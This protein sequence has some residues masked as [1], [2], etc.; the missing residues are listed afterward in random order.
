[1]KHME[2]YVKRLNTYV[3][4][5]I[6]DVF[7]VIIW[8]VINNFLLENIRTEEKKRVSESL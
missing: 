4:K 1:M 7:D 5:V 6:T 3:V 8:V 2:T